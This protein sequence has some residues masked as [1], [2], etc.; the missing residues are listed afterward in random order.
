M[1]NR[2]LYAP[3]TKLRCLR[4]A[5]RFGKLVLAMHELRNESGWFAALASVV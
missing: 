5:L 3:E 2:F 4:N 1:S